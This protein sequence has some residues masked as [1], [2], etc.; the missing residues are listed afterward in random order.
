MA[1]TFV[2]EDGTGLSTANS[3]CE[4]AFAD[5]WHELNNNTTWAAAATL[6]KQLAL[7]KA[8]MY[9]DMR[10][11]PKFRGLR[12]SRE[13]A[14]EWPRLA[15]KDNDG[16]FFIDTTEIPL[17]LK[18]ATAEYAFRLLTLTDLAPDPSSSS[19]PGQVI[20]V[21]EVVGP[22][23]TRTKYASTSEAQG[24]GRSPQSILIDDSLI[25]QY[26]QADMWLA[27]L[28]RSSRSKRIIRG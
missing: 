18:R 23:K 1:Y 2:V 20:E 14:L 17:Q 15:A 26:P 27:E 12:E 8:T 13:Q 11:G 25:P 24:T 19:N 9:I 28:V 5:D 22:I 10:F 3:Y 4:V 6:T 7:S 16:W 21:E